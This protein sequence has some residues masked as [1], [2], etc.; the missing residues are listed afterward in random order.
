MES[1]VLVNN[2]CS[3]TITPLPRLAQI[4]PVLGIESLDINNDNYVDLLI[5]GNNYGAEDDVVR[6]DA[7][8]GLALLGD[9]TGSGV[10]R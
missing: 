4:S 1:V 5:S 6:Y 2:G 10:R 3:F 9:G 7:G 8:K